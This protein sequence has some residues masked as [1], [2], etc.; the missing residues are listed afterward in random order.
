MNLLRPGTWLRLWQAAVAVMLTLALTGVSWAADEEEDIALDK[1][2]AAVVKAVKDKFPEG[3]LVKA[4]KEVDGDKATYEVSLTNKGQAIDVT[5]TADGKIELI[6]KE[7]A[8]KDLPK[9]IRST[10]DAKYPKAEIQK[11]EEITEGDKPKYEVILVTADKKR[12]EVELDAAGK[13]I[14]ETELKV[15]DSEEEIALDKLPEAVVKAV[16][17]KFPKGKLVSAEKAVEDGVTTYEVSLKDG[18]HDV[19]VKLSAAGKIAEIERVIELKDLP[20]AVRESLDAK[21]AKATIKKIEEATEGDKVNYEVEL[22]T[23]DKKQLAVVFDATGK[24]IEEEEAEK[25]EAK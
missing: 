25:D 17:A 24:V 2:P 5:L 23:A 3:K 6:E 20:K 13:V 1:L 14:E 7:I 16:K 4:S 8:A 9:A 19:S 21:Y 15:E 18:E 12:L 22:V 11:A 10:L